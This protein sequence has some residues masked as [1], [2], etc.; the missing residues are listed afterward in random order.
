[1]PD[2]NNIQP[3]NQ[4]AV[5]PPTSAVNPR[6][7]GAFKRTQPVAQ[8]L[9]PGELITINIDVPTAVTTVEAKLPALLAM[10]ERI[11]RELPTF[12][13]SLFDQLGTY[14]AATGYAHGLYLAASAPPEALTK[15]TAEGTVMRDTLYSDAA[16]LAHRG[17]INGDR[18]TEFKAAAGYK[19]LAFDLIGLA[20]LLLENWERIVGKSALQLAEIERAELLGEQ[21]VAAVGTRDQAPA[22]VSEVAQQR[23]RMFTLFLRSYDQVRRAVTFLYWNEDNVED[24]CPSL[25]SGRTARRKTD[26]P[27][28]TAGNV[29][30]QPG[31]GA[32]VQ[33]SQATPVAAVAAASASKAPG[34]PVIP[35]GMPG[36]APFGGGE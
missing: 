27:V 10:R 34:A 30:G 23:Q 32:V 16:A 9:A 18:L 33:G 4:G 15:L 5:P 11:V 13:I 3:S 6:F 35:V 26:T 31:A 25:Y 28:S 24:L 20:A 36:S 8:A 12:D 2:S 17:L 1:M 14:S 21:L 22:V 29:V 19:N 7:R